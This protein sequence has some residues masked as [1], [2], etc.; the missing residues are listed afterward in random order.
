ML[1][2]CG[3]LAVVPA[4]SFHR[5]FTDSMSD[6][7]LERNHPLSCF[8]RRMASRISPE[9]LK[10]NE[11][12]RIVSLRLT[13]KALGFVFEDSRLKVAYHARGQHTRH[14]AHDIDAV[15]LLHGENSSDLSS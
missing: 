12:E 2:F 15:R 5:G 8:S 14:L 1:E 3:A 6:T 4:K 11:L 7:F 9:S 10:I 13:R